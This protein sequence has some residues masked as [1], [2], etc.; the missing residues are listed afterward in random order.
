MNLDDHLARSVF[1][2]CLL[3]VN[4]YSSFTK[5]FILQGAFVNPKCKAI[6]IALL[7]NR[8]TVY[9]DVFN[10]FYLMC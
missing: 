2:S 3:V 7:M 4:V 10:Y 1:K 5:Y 6:Q 8:I 9:Y